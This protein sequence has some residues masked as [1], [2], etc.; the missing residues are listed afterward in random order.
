VNA[1]TNDERQQ[2][3]ERAIDTQEPKL[4]QEGFHLD[5]VGPPQGAEVRAPGA[6]KEASVGAGIEFVSLNTCTRIQS[7]RCNGVA[8]AASKLPPST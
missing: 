8:G 6:A 3:T 2:D 4:T 5:T 7:T 1:E